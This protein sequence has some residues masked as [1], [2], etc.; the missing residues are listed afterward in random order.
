MAQRITHI[1]FALALSYYIF[2]NI[3]FWPDIVLVEFSS[4]L[5]AVLPDL[6]VKFGHRALLHNIF[7]PLSTF[8][9]LTFALRCAFGSN[10]IAVSVSYLIGFLS[11]VLLDLFTGGVSLL[12]P[13]RCRRFI[14]LKVRYDNPVFNLAVIFLALA[15]FYVRFKAV[16]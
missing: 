10:F 9:P 4:F 13:I 14:L 12:Y 11:H 8:I 5:G 16:F 3:T 15:L 1:I 2:G 7:I 6:D